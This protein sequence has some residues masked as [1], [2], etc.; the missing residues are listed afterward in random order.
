MSLKRIRLQ[1]Y[2]AWIVLLLG[3]SLSAVNSYYVKRDIEQKAIESLG[4][5]ADQVMTRI[6]ERLDAYALV[7]RGAAG[8][9]Y[10]SEYI[11]RSEWRSYYS[12]LEVSESITGVQGVG[13]A[14]LIP[15]D[16][17]ASHIA[18]VQAEGFPDYHVRPEGPRDIYTSIVYLEPFNERNQRAFGYDMYS[19]PVRRAA[20]A[21]RM[22][23]GRGLAAL[24]GK[25]ALLQETETDVQVGTLM[26]VPIYRNGAVLNNVA[27]RRAALIE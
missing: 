6:E 17:L 18:S 20:M 15:P 24:S 2:V 23:A 19:E 22:S 10:A 16:Q 7:L 9:F 1:Q 14:V 26:Y 11:S 12:V 3:I 27:D 21:F 25:V 8:L 4:F 13:F 5:A